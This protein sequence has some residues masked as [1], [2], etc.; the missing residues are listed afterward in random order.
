MACIGM[1]PTTSSIALSTRSSRM[2]TKKTQ[3]I[4]LAIHLRLTVF[5]PDS[6]EPGTSCTGRAKNYIVDGKMTGGVAFVA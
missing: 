4:K 3:R 6:K 1:V 2:R 5:F